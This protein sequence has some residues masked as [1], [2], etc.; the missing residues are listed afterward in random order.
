M[1]ARSTIR[2][3]SSTLNVA[4]VVALAVGGAAAEEAKVKFSRE[5]RPIL[6]GKCLKCHGPDEAQ[7]QSGLRLDQREAAIGKGD[8]E[9]LAILPGKPDESELIRR[10]SSTDASEIMP[11]PEEKKPLT[12]EQIDTL[13]RWVEQGAEYES[14][15]AFATPTKPEVPRVEGAKGSGFGVQSSEA[16][17]QN[18]ASNKDSASRIQTPAFRVFNEIDAFICDRLQRE[19]LTMSPAADK[20]T[21]LRR[22]T[23]DLTGLP[24]T[25]DELEA[26][27]SD[28]S[29]NAYEKV[30]DR[31]LHSSRYGERMVL[32]W[33]DAARYADTNGYQGDQTRTMWPWRDWVIKALNDNM[34]FDRFTIEQLAGDLLPGATLE[35]R[36]ATGF[37]RNHPLN[38]EGGRIP[39]ESRNDY[40]MD[41]VETL[42]TVWLGLTIGCCRCHDHKY[43]PVTQREYYQLFAYFNQVAEIGGVD[44]GGNA[45]P[46]MR[47]DTADVKQRLAGLR[48]GLEAAQQKLDNVLSQMDA[49]QADWE[50]TLTDDDLQNLPQRIRRAL[51]TASDQR[52]QDDRNAIQDFYR[53]ELAND[54]KLYQEA[55]R[56]RREWDEYEQKIP[57]TMVMEELPQARETW[58]LIRGIYDKHGDRVEAGVPSILPPLPEG[59]PKNRLALAKWLVDPA[60]PL[61]ARVTVNRYWQMFFGTGLVKTAEDFGVQGEFPSHL[62][63]LDWL[64]VRF[65]ESGW[66]V[67]AMHRLI[68]TSAAYRQSSNVTSEL[69]Q[70]DPENR[71]LARGPRFRLSSYALRDQALAV[72]GLLVEKVGGPSVKPYMPGGV[73]EDASLGKISYERDKGDGLYRR[74]LYTFWRRIAS[75]T[76]FFDASSRQIC[77]VRVP[78]TNT[79][80]QALLLMND[81][82]HVEAARNLASRAMEKCDDA[83]QRLDLAF[84]LCTARH[85]TDKEQEMLL[86]AL[87]DFQK[88]FRDN[89]DAAER[90]IHEGDSPRPKDIDPQELAAYTMA[91]SLIMNLDETLTKE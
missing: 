24:P 5:V 88:H 36:I 18:P 43:D 30:V 34:P 11:P 75:P 40:V 26:F 53:D 2:L 28:D 73:W 46:V 68:V 76:M 67:K 23:F 8:S 21:L 87:E 47:M 44:A 20:A 4:A 29:P 51:T 3:W 71:L 9:R 85:A 58:I 7:R 80:L 25:I 90:L 12:P 32:E 41:R 70:V 38:G 52:T 37:N 89:K 49:G 14:H 57:E 64:A 13:R 10:I 56:A 82:Q 33:L 22:V 31:L 16:N 86:A 69:E 62:E 65:I 61:T 84:R 83:D 39:E 66:D 59:A 50:R 45:K 35:Q 63:L 81:V 79:P 42:G 60:N 91:I 72:S 48:G 17:G 77:T 74:S 55:K 54:R 15:W 1:Y 19:G 27:L 6:A 78:R